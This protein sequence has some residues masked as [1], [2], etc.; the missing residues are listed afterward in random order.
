MRLYTCAGSRG[1]RVSWLAEEMGLSLDYKM[2]PFPPRAKAKDYLVTNPLGTVPMLVDGKI[3]LTESSAI[4]FYLASK[5]GPTDLF[6][7][8]DEPDFGPM[9]DYLHHADATLTFPQTVYMRFS[10]FEKE[11]GLR[12]A[13]DA[14]AKWFAARLVK[15][16]QRLNGRDYLCADRFTI[17][18]IA[19]GYALY[20]ST[21]NGLSDRLPE[22]VKAYLD[23]VTGRPAFIRAVEKEREAAAARGVS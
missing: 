23:R 8:S 14:Y 12:S 2:L 7:G 4:L 1:L 11:K 22:D 21:R 9:H 5:Y 20:L 13:G 3:E 10:I 17:A 15:I 19:I 6:V 16:E 18:D